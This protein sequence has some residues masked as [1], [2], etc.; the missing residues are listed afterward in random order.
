MIRRKIFLKK[1]LLAGVIACSIGAGTFLSSGMAIPALAT[2]VGIDIGDNGVEETPQNTD[3]KATLY[4]SYDAGYEMYE[5]SMNDLFFFYCNIGNGSFTSDPVVFDFPNNIVYSVEKDGVEVPYQNH[6]SITNP[7]NYVVRLSAEYNGT[8]YI[9]TFRFAL[10]EAVVVDETITEDDLNLS[11]EDLVIDPNEDISEEDIDAM[12]EQSGASLDSSMVSS[13]VNGVSVNPYTG[14]LQSFEP[15]TM[16]YSFALQSGEK[17]F[18]NIPMGAIVNNNVSLTI[19]E[20]VQTT[21]YKNGELVADQVSL[22][23]TEPGFYKVQFYSAT[24][25]FYRFYPDEKKYPFVTFKIVGEAANDIEIFTAPEGCKI[26][27][28]STELGTYRDEEGNRELSLNQ[29][30]LENEDLYVFKVYDPSVDDSYSVSIRRDITA[31]VG[32]MSVNKN[33]ADLYFDSPDVAYVEVLKNG[34]PEQYVG[35]HFEGKGDYI[36]YVYDYAG[37]RSVITFTLKDAFNQGTFFTI[38][39]L[40]ILVLGGFIYLRLKKTYVTVR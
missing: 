27:G 7:G 28:V 20:G 39:I 34:F 23:F 14:M 4:E 26:I 19:P 10:R 24:T 9:S 16:M 22:N 3:V 37:N 11:A 40:V 13:T 25:N 30:W 35:N 21:V 15:T 12:I 36:V 1:Q 2:E 8:K 6:G 29:F 33:K 38:L 32:H 17:I 31:P 5:E 18:S